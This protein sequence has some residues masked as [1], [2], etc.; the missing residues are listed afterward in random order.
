MGFT[1]NGEGTY[2]EEDEEVNKL[3]LLQ[4]VIEAHATHVQ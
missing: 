2:L 1:R 3:P 4:S